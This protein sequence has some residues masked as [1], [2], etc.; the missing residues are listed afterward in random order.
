MG[1]YPRPFKQDSFLVYVLYALSFIIQTQLTMVLI[2]LM[3]HL[4][5]GEGVSSPSSINSCWCPVL[6][7][8]PNNSL[9]ISF[10]QSLPLRNCLKSIRATQISKRSGPGKPN[11]NGE[12][13]WVRTRLRGI[14]SRMPHTVKTIQFGPA[15]YGEERHECILD[16][17]GQA[18]ATIQCVSVWWR[19][20]QSH[21][22][23]N[24]MNEVGD[25]KNISKSKLEDVE[26]D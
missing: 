1:K 11:F 19:G 25:P 9:Q 12:H 3:A 17:K 23:S 24:Q 4:F 5:G 21:V 18:K 22:K 14:K 16:T 13:Q 8:F 2:C 20:N 7:I 15:S 26:M 6:L 10:F